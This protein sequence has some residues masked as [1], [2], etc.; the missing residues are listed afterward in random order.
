MA[1]QRQT[2]DGPP[3]VDE[4][5]TAAYEAGWEPAE[6]DLATAPPE[7][8]ALHL[9]LTVTD[10]ELRAGER[11][12]SAADEAVAAIRQLFAAP[13]AVDWR[14][15]GG[16]FVTSV[17]NQASCGSCVSF[18]TLATIES[19]ANIV[20]RTPGQQRDYSEAYLFYCGCGNCCGTGW[21]FA[22]ALEFCKNTGVAAEAKFPYTPGNQPCRPGVTPDFKITGY[23]V[24]PSQAERRA[25]IADGGP[26]VAGMAVYQDF[27]AYKSGIYKHVSGGLVGYH[28]IS[29]VGYD[30]TQQ[31][32]IC[33]NS[34]GTGWGDSGFFRIAYGQCGIDTQ[35]PFY[36]PQVPC[37]TPPCT[38]YV[39][40]L[41]RVIVAARANP[42]LRRCLLYYICGRGR[43][44]ICPASHARVV[45]LVRRILATCPQYRR[46]FCSAI[47]S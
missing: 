15:N 11:M 12:I 39:T 31:C 20:C 9:G 16:N 27:Y 34:W 17:K 7:E 41:R 29:V 8:Q 45:Q 43:R 21:N 25:A 6:T 38:Q 22:P 18:A 19:R 40:H 46:A 10:E 3:G 47:M 1:R 23:T 33:K 14:N 35:F 13:P 26:V 24:L 36:A 42:S 5:R 28:A 32:W 2:G 37:P 4:I 30:D 44:P